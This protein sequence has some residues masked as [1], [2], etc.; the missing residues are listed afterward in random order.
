[1]DLRTFNRRANQRQP[2]PTTRFEALHKWV[3][4]RTRSLLPA[5]TRPL[6]H[7]APPAHQLTIPILGAEP[8]PI[9]TAHHPFLPPL[10]PPRL[11]AALPNAR[12][13]AFPTALVDHLFAAIRQA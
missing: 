2:M 7:P 4:A 11:P 3:G 8:L 6:H 5:Q 1:D 10:P 9:H 12:L 13:L